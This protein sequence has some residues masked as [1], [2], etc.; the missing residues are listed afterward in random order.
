MLIEE[1]K[2]LIRENDYFK[3]E[4][5]KLQEMVQSQKDEMTLLQNKLRQQKAQLQGQNVVVD[6]LSKKVA[7]IDDNMDPQ[8]EN[9]R[10]K[11]E[12]DL[13]IKKINNDDYLNLIQLREKNMKLEQE[14]N[15]LQLIID[16]LCAKINK[17][18]DLEPKQAS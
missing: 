11:L 2:K 7:S 9:K 16:A 1:N 5:V 18:N 14:K 6:V 17:D 15:V 3:R 12:M 13:L 8:S 4:E 10:L